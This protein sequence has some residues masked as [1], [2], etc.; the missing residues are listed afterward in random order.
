MKKILKLEIEVDIEVEDL[1][2]NPQSRSRHKE[3]RRVTIDYPRDLPYIL[4][5]Q[6][7]L[8]LN[9]KFDPKKGDIGACGGM[10][11][12]SIYAKEI[13]TS[14]LFIKRAGNEKA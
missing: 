2:S 7:A 12:G 1:V 13:P 9:L 10:V 11:P 14:V 8:Q 5:G 4:A 6:I 3:N